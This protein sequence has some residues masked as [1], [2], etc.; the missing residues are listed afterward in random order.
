V[1][2]QPLS[3]DTGPPAGSMLSSPRGGDMSLRLGFVYHCTVAYVSSV[4]SSPLIDVMVEGGIAARLVSAL[5][6]S[7]I[8]R[9]SLSPLAY[10]SWCEQVHDVLS[11]L[12]YRVCT[13]ERPNH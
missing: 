1:V 7:F 12:G 11:S 5:G 10:I 13:C 4:A 9:H 8:C 2:G 6:G 3:P